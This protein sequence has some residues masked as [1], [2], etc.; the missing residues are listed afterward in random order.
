MGT[1][2]ICLYTEVDKTYTGYNS[3]TTELLDC[4]LIGVCAVIRANMVDTFLLKKST[5]SRAIQE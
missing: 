4:V 3:K 2:N 5:L 1:H